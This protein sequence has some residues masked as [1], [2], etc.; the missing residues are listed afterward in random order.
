VR[1]L[2]VWKPSFDDE[3]TRHPPTRSS[4]C[5][6][7][8][9][10]PVTDRCPI[11]QHMHTKTPCACSVPALALQHIHGLRADR[12]PSRV[13]FHTQ[14]GP[15]GG[16]ARTL[17][18]RR[19]RRATSMWSG[20]CGAGRTAHGERRLRRACRRGLRRTRKRR[21]ERRLCGGPLYVGDACGQADVRRATR[22][23]ERRLRWAGTLC[24]CRVVLAARAKRC[25]ERAACVATCEPS[26]RT[27]AGGSERGA[28]GEA[29][30]CREQCRCGVRACVGALCE[31]GLE[32]SPP[33]KFVLS[34]W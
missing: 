8:V 7:C 17:G 34:A 6:C 23:R 29:T 12:R 15:C 33:Q 27:L 20:T 21:A 13:G 30:A 24:V 3:G 10:T 32:Q 11:M 28:C 31:P 5:Q 14:S 25:A 26:A 16:P 2:V 4:E 18:D 22:P 9:P 19:L 1:A